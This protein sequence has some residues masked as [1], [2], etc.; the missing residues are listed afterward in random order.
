M[1]IILLIVL[2]FT[3]ILFGCSQNEETQSTPESKEIYLLIVEHDNYEKAIE[4]VKEYYKG[5]ELEERLK[6]AN[7]WIEIR[8]S[9]QEELADAWNRQVPSSRLE[10]DKNFTQE[11]TDNYVYIKGRVK[12]TSN[13]NV[14]YFKVLVDFLDESGNILDSG[15]TNDSL[16]LKAGA[17]REFQIMHRKIDGVES[18]RL[19]IDH[20]R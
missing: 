18:V 14:T 20:V 17:T 6:W 10:L 15:Y 7:K 9:S 13:Y 3:F 1:R 2:C 19:S 16:L 12:N 5:E 11:H 8:K 4:K